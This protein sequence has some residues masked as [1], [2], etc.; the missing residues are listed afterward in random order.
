MQFIFPWFGSD[1]SFFKKKLC[2]DFLKTSRFYLFLCP[3]IFKNKCWLLLQSCYP[4]I[5]LMQFIFLRER[6]ILSLPAEPKAKGPRNSVTTAAN[7]PYRKKTAA[8][9][10]MV[11]LKQVLVASSILLLRHQ[12]VQLFFCGKEVPVSFPFPLNQK[13]PGNSFTTAASSVW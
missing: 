13:R 7:S 2:L 5:R 12:T 4:D 3:F 1:I 11:V 8:K 6:S 10:R 9:Q